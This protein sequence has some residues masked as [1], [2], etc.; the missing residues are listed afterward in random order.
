M[1]NPMLQTHLLPPFS[2]ISPADIEPAIDQLLADNRQAISELLTS[3]QGANTPDWSSFV[4]PLESMHDR[5]AQAWS[6]V[7]HMNAVV[8][9]DELREAYNA[10]LPKLSQYWTELGQNRGLYE[11]FRAIRESDGFD[12]LSVAQQKMI[13]DQLRDFRLSG[14]ALP[15]AQQQRYGELKQRLSELTTKFSENVLDA[16]G[17]WQKQISDVSELA[18]LPE[19]ALAV[20]QQQAQAKAL[21]GWLITLDFP[22][23]LAVMTHAENRELRREVYEAFAT[24]ASD[25]GPHAGKWD[26]SDIMTEI[27]TLRHELAA[28]LGFEHYGEYSLATKMAESSEQ[29]VGFLTDLAEKSQTVARQDYDELVAF[30]QTQG[31]DDPQ[32]WDLTFYGEQLKEQKYSVSQQ[33]LR[34]YFPMPKVLDG[35]FQVAGRLFD[36]EIHEL[37]DFDSWHPDAR[38]FEISREGDAIARFFLDAYARYKKRGGAW[39]DDCR[40]RRRL[41]DGAVQ[42]P[43]AYLVC[44]FSGPVGDDPALLTHD[45]VTTLFHEFGHGLHHMLTRIETAAVSGINGVPWDAVE[46]PSQFM[47][48]WCWEPEAL[49]LISGH[50]QTGESLPQAMLE[51]MLAAKNYQS[52]MMMVR[53]L[54]FALFDFRLHME[55]TAGETDIQAVLNA[56]REQVAV[57]QPPAFNRFQHGFSHIFAGGYAAGYYSYKWAEVLSAD[58]FSRFE[59]EGIFNA[60][61]GADFRRTVLEQ[62]GSREPMALFTEFR[63]RT[64]QVDALLR[65]SG[66]TG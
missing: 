17:G 29:V 5:L 51:R 32:A 8:N 50:Y 55:Y 49:A 28:L 27:L 15:E 33:A 41:D 44:N 6:P 52:G 40:V 35:L 48:N 13:E 7:S 42:L 10:C 37:H 36:I 14:I 66:I 2:Q 53:Q 21:D 30:A 1:S 20:A 26:N 22:S 47:E 19:M 23:Y 18:G 24:R 25:Q 45:E 12:S 16:T 57:V 63:G 58:A 11:A 43:V 65:H 60:Q 9:S 64:P 62:G 46:L 38:L 3:L 4:A 56:V 59:E 54:E 31:L 39:M 34:P 61:A